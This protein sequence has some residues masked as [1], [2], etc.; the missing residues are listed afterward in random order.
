MHAAGINETLHHLHC[1]LNKQKKN[2]S[3]IKTQ[4]NK[5]FK[6]CHFFPP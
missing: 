6:P 3:K 1:E 5:K 4:L 2:Y